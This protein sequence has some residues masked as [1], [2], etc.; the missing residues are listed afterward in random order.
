MPNL[1]LDEQQI[2]EIVNAMRTANHELGAD[3]NQGIPDYLIDAMPAPVVTLKY[4]VIV[5]V[6]HYEIDV[7]G[8]RDIFYA[9]R[10][11]LRSHGFEPEVHVNTI[12]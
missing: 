2:V 12:E 1:M 10:N 4:E 3:D 9:V 8:E 6:P 7:A 11:H 5:A